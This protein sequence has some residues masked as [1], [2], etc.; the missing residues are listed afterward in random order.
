MGGGG[1]ILSGVVSILVL[2][3]GANR[4]PEPLLSCVK[5]YIENTDSH[6]LR[7]GV[8][9]VQC[10]GYLDPPVLHVGVH[11]I[12]GPLAWHVGVY[13]TEDLIVCIV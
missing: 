4:M 10:I 12:P 8:H 11:F 2:R 9:S 3:G 7:E 1:G 5:V 13:Q 6:V